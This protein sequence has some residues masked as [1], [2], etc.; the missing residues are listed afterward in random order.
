MF[1]RERLVSLTSPVLILGM[2]GWVDAGYG[3]SGA[4]AALLGAL[5][6]EPIVTFDGD[7]LIDYRSRRPTL[8]ID[9]GV[10]TGLTWNDIVLRAGADSNGNDVLLLTGPEPDMKWRAFTRSIVDLA[11]EHRVRLTVSLGAFPAPVPHTRG[12]RLA[13]TASSAEL[14]A[15]IGYVPGVIDVP[16]GIHSVL[17]AALDESGVPSVGLWARV[18]HYVAAMPY[19]AASAALIE[20][21]ASLA[22]LALD[23]SELR[24][25]AE[26]TRTRIDHLIAQSDEHVSMVANLESQAD[27][28]QSTAGFAGLGDLPSGDELAAELERFLRGER[29]GGS[30]EPGSG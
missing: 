26:V 18:P 17:E 6:T 12:V 11:R 28:E 30:A 10:S 9:N 14:A 24:A 20:G 3:G 25:A 8:R 23:S 13:S 27:A 4:V 15:R 7:E 5:R 2:D 1:T 19:P 29:G 22:G 16:G 21:L